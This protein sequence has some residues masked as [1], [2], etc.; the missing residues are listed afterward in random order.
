MTTKTKLIRTI[1]LYIAALASL[2]F[3]AAGAG[4]LINTALKAYVFPKAEKGGYSRC[5]QQ[6]PVYGLEK[7]IYSGVTTEEK[8]TQLDNL[9]RDYENWQR[10]NTGEEC[11]SAERQNNAVNA[12][13]M[14]IVALPIFLF[15]WNI[16]RKEK[17]EKGE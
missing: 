17:N 2:I 9:L 7:G 6:P 13:T 1:Y 5:N 16:I 15:H 4:N 11:Y 14:M 10:E 12:L 8:Q 3:V